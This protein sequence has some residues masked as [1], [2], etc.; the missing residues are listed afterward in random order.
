[1]NEQF[2]IYDKGDFDK[3]SRGISYINN[4]L[5]IWGVSN[6]QNHVD[7]NFADTRGYATVFVEWPGTDVVNSRGRYFIINGE[8]KSQGYFSTDKDIG[9]EGELTTI[10]GKINELETGFKGVLASVDIF[11]KNTKLAVPSHLIE[12]IMHKQLIE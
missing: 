12:L 10:G 11:S 7:V 4:I 3:A 1:M 5:R 6:R 2:I 8:K 9:L